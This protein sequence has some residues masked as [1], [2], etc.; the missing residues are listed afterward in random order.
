M[1]A[2]DGGRSER[3]DSN[4]AQRKRLAIETPIVGGDGE[5]GGGVRDAARGASS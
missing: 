1:E 2:G 5:G 3:G 4:P